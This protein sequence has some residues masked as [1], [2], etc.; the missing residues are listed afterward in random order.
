[1][2]RAVSADQVLFN[3]CIEA[4]YYNQNGRESSKSPHDKCGY[5]LLDFSLKETIFTEHF[6]IEPSYE[7]ILPGAYKAFISR[8]NL[9]I[10]AENSLDSHLF[11][12]GLASVFSF[13]TGRPVK[14]PRDGYISSRE[15]SDYA[16]SELAIIF[17]ILS[18]G[19]G[20]H[21]TLISSEAFKKISNNIN[22]IVNLLYLLPYDKYKKFMQSIRLVHLGLNSKRE[23]FGLGYY[24]LVSAIEPIATQAI[25]RKTV[26]PD[27]PELKKWREL[28]KENPAIQKI[29]DAYQQEKSKNR[30]ISK[31]FVEFVLRYCPPE[32]WHYLEHP[33]ENF[34]QVVK[35]MSPSASIDWITDK[36]PFEIYPSDLGIDE[37]KTILSDVYTHR[38]KY[39]HEGSNPPHKRIYDTDRFFITDYIN[40][41]SVGRDS[42]KLITLPKFELISFI[43]QRSISN[44]LKE[45]SQV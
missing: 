2:T 12:I 44:Y 38:S 20:A 11:T 36:S 19:P 26:A 14:A 42:F 45:V 3:E 43:A 13:A 33:Q 23:D 24:L 17:P 1:M 37:I 16:L 31:R 30:Y 9:P 39:T 18:A 22:E 25:K 27:N 10:W 41:E 35:E 8:V 6:S 32:E 28:A 34:T 15:L 29:I 21:S 40:N 4:F 7:V 5:L